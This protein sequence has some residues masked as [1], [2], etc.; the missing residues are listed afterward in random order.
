MQDNSAISVEVYS[1][2]YLCT[3]L[4]NFEK[5]GCLTLGIIFW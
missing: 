1:E 3:L 5:F 2:A 4:Q